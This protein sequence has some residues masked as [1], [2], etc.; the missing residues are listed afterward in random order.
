MK[1]ALETLKPC[2]TSE[3]SE[4]RDHR[5]TELYCAIRV[6]IYCEY[7]YVWVWVP[8]LFRVWNSFDLKTH[9]PH[10]HPGLYSLSLVWIFIDGC[11]QKET[12]CA[13]GVF[14]MAVS[15]LEEVRLCFLWEQPGAIKALFRFERALQHSSALFEWEGHQARE[16]ESC[17][18]VSV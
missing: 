17:H 16:L 12:P 6:L 5:W 10:S 4:V 15:H 9:L 13:A 11:C 3:Q 18:R 7:I 2:C 8:L 14:C 1:G